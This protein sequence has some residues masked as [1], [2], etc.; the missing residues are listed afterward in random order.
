[1]LISSIIIA[2]FGVPTK[3]QSSNTT[4]GA[5]VIPLVILIILFGFFI[6]M[7]YTPAYAEVTSA[8]SS[9]FFVPSSGTEDD[10]EDCSDLDENADEEQEDGSGRSYG[11]ISAV[12]CLGEFSMMFYPSNR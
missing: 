2:F 5:G 6:N 7:V 4:L 3:Q 11:L 8:C 12:V 1:M 10:D 9:C